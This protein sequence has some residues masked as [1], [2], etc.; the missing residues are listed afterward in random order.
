MKRF[1]RV[2][3][4]LVALA[5]IV[6]LAPAGLFS[7]QS[8]ATAP[9]KDDGKTYLHAVWENKDVGLGIKW[10]GNP[11]SYPMTVQLA[12]GVMMGASWNE[13]YLYLSVNTDEVYELKVNGKNVSRYPYDKYPDN[14]FAANF[15]EY[16]IRLD[17]AVS[18]LESGVNTVT[19]KLTETA[20]E[21]TLYLI[22][23]NNNYTKYEIAVSGNLASAV[24]DNA[25]AATFGGETAGNSYM[26]ADGSSLTPS[27]NN[28]TVVELD[29]D[30]DSLNAGYALDAS[31]GK[32]V[33]YVTMGVNIQVMDE[34]VALNGTIP[35]EAFV[36]GFTKDKTTGNFY[37][38]SAVSTGTGTFT[39]SDVLLSETVGGFYHVRVEYTYAPD[40]NGEVSR[41]SVVSAKYYL[42]GKLIDACENVRVSCGTTKMAA[43][44]KGVRLYTSKLDNNVTVSNIS[45]SYSDPAALATLEE[46]VAANYCT[47]QGHTAPESATCQ[48]QGECTVCGELVYGDHAWNDATCTAPK[49]CSVCGAEEGEVGDH[50]LTKV[51]ANGATCEADGNVEYWHCS[52]CEKNFDAEGEEIADVTVKGDH[53]LEKVEANAPTCEADGNVEYWHCSVCEKNFNAE[54]E[55]IAD[56]T[57]AGGHELEKVEANAPTCDAA[58]NVEYWH[59]SVCEKNFDAEGEEIADVTIAGGHDLEKVEANAPTC[60]AAGNVEYWHCSVCEKNFDAE[61]EEIADV[62]IAGGHDLEKVEANAPTCDAAGNV[63]Y[64]HCSV[65]EKNFNAE[66]EEIADVTV[67][68]GHNYGNLIDRVDA[69]HTK[70]E[71]KAGMEAH[72]F[73]EACQTYFDADKKATTYD[74]LVIPAPEHVYDEATGKCQCGAVDENVTFVAEVDGVQYTSLQAA[75]DAAEGE[76]VNLLANVDLNKIRLTITTNCTLDLNGYTLTSK[77]KGD[78]TNA[79]AIYVQAGKTFTLADSVGTG[80]VVSTCYGVYVKEGATFNMTGGTI[81]LPGN[82]VYDLGVIT[83][84]ANFNMTGGTIKAR[85]GVWVCDYYD[86]AAASNVVIDGGSIIVS[87][88]DHEND[89]SNAIVDDPSYPKGATITVK[90]GAF[91]ELNSVMPYVESGATIA[92]SGDVALDETVTVTGNVVIDLNGK[93]ISGDFESAYGMIYVKKGATL[94]IKGEGAITAAATHAIGNYGTV[95]IE[96]GVITTAAGEDYAALYN[97]YYA[98]YGEGTAIVNGGELNAV[99]NCGELTVNS[100]KIDYIDTSSELTVTDGEIANIL[101]KDGSDANGAYEIAIADPT[102]IVTE[103]DFELKKVSEGIYTVVAK[104]YVAQIG[105]KKFESLKAAIDAAKDGDVITLLQS[106]SGAGIVID[107]SITIDFGGYTYTFNSPAVGSSG[108]QTL[109]FQILE[110]NTVVLKNGTLEVAEAAKTDFAML[111]QNYADLTVSGMTLDGTN[112][113]RY[114]IKDYNYSYVLSNNSGNVEIIDTTIIVNDGGDAYAF[115]ACKY[116]SYAVPTVTVSGNSNISG[117]VEVTGGNLVLNGGTFTGKLVYASGS[118]TKAEAV[119]LA[120]PADYKWVNGIL[121]AKDYVAQIG[122]KKFESLKAAVEAAENGDVITLLQSV[123]G[124]GIVIDKSITIDFGGYTYTFNSPAVGSSGTQTLG[125]QILEN[126]TVVLKNGTLEVAEAAKTDF[127]MLIQNYADLTVSGMTLDGTNLDRYTIKD[128]NYSYVLSNNSGNVEIIDTTII[129]NDGGDAYAFDACKYASYA[130]PTV[131]VSGNSNISGIV[132]VTGGNLVLNG[133]TFTGKLVYASGSVTKAEAVE[134]AAP[135]GYCWNAE[136]VLGAHVG[137]DAVEEGRVESSCTVAGSYESVVYCAHCGE[138]LSRETVDLPLAEHT[139]G[140][141]VE[142][143]RTESTCT[144]AGSYESVVYCSVCGTHEISRETVDLP[145]AEHTAGEAVEENRTEST[146]TVAGS[147]ESVVYCSVCGTHEISRET[148]DL[149]LAEHTAGEAVEENRTEST[150]TVAGSYESVVYCSVCGT[151]EISRETVDLPLAEHNFDNGECT[152]CHIEDPDYICITRDPDNAEGKLGGTVEFTVQLNKTEGVSYQWYFSDTQG[153]TWAKSSMTGSKTATLTVDVLAHRVGHMYKC[154]ITDAEGNILDESEPATLIVP[155]DEVV[156]DTQPTDVYTVNGSVGQ[157]HV[158]ASHMEGATYQ[159]YFSNTDG[160]TWAKSGMDGAKTDTLTV[161]AYTSR[162]GQKYKCVITDAYGN[163]FESDPATLY[164]KAVGVNIVKQ[165]TDAHVA[166]GEYTTFSVIVEETEDVYFQWYYSNNGGQTWSKSGMAGAKSSSL[167]VQLLTHRVGQMYK[168]VI[169]DAYGNVVETNEVTLSN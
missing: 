57:I 130:V 97:F 143:N 127:A 140:E 79:M 147:Y 139:A 45:V 162:N 11:D 4:F 111:I 122:E 83:W 160:V 31:V 75:V 27:L 89:P 107:K 104:N 44:L 2:S 50:D 34:L 128:Y 120:A 135:E 149:P 84:N 94:T 55:E 5:L 110:N 67:E 66:G 113:D 118:V 142:E 15:D 164:V 105:E 22:F 168:C 17:A 124:A 90:K 115:D 150:C 41:D 156:F 52:V 129:V 38:Q 99:F 3:A 35:T 12:D 152:E 60:D 70:E 74:A 154:V 159:W 126:N 26:T 30:I 36:F 62:T 46:T 157:F 71:L 93:T 32:N 144:V 91:N 8:S 21:Q 133:G 24:E 161:Q 1:K 146:C 65:C 29:I 48:V 92:L 56:V 95:T 101:A 141:A 153:E 78:S 72:Y 25:Y 131:T 100:G 42:N 20:E 145:L 123:S 76:T 81:E 54:G 98:G 6:G 108:T 10:D 68:G 119:G 121:T 69:V 13:T 14:E 114:T 73:C 7:V 39:S 132:E 169:T 16:R 102:V 18:S 138:E 125:F 116:A 88:V 148:V 23:D 117:I 47:K 53:D 134:L 80:K 61:G 33:R 167:A 58:G 86:D 85:V 155:K 37:F 43:S 151:H 82:A 28:T 49:T 40:A 103:D 136:G 106:V 96:G 9:S 163:T 63:E 87:G 59:C 165:P 112:L 51:D 109:G 77:D 64:W 19:V 158:E 137:G 166:I